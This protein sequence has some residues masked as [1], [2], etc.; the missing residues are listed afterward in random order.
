MHQIW[1]DKYMKSQSIRNLISANF[2][3]KNARKIT[4]SC[5]VTI[6]SSIDSILILHRLSSTVDVVFPAQKCITAF[7]APAPNSIMICDP[8]QKVFCV[9]K[10]FFVAFFTF[11]SP[12]VYFTLCYAC[13]LQNQ[14]YAYFSGAKTPLPG[15]EFDIWPK[16]CSGG[17][18]RR[19]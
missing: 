14:E 16:V 4:P 15:A 18:L 19:K 10:M 5:L 12:F 17:D 7:R 1:P 11:F 9:L 3:P 13:L 2:Y 6:K 8:S